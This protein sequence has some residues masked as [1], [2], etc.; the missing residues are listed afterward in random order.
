[1]LV[2]ASSRG[3]HKSGRMR[4]DSCVTLQK[5]NKNTCPQHRCGTTEQ[6]MPPLTRGQL[7]SPQ[8]R[9]HELGIL[10]VS[11]RACQITQRIRGNERD[12]CMANMQLIEC[13]LS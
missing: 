9:R 1:M 6:Y 5:P 3:D 11:K 2:P 12:L 10:F 8:H 13:Y 4:G 7:E